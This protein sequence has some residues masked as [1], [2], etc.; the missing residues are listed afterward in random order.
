MGVCGGKQHKKVNQFRTVNKYDVNSLL[1]LWVIFLV[2]HSSFSLQALAKF[3]RGYCL[4]LFVIQLLTKGTLYFS[5]SMLIHTLQ[6]R[7]FVLAVACQV[8]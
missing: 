8:S 3:Q 6:M 4:S 1:R 5:I 2:L 7:I